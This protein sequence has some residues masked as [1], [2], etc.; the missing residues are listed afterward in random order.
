MTPVSSSEAAAVD[1]EVFARQ[2][3]LMNRN[4]RSGFVGSALGIPLLGVALFGWS[5]PMSF[6]IWAPASLGVILGAWLRIERLNSQGVATNEQRRTGMSYVL[7]DL[8]VGVVWG[9]AMVVFFDAQPARLAVL[10]MALLA[11]VV[12]A[13]GATAVF[14][15]SLYAFSAAGVVG[16]RRAGEPRWCAAARA[17][18]GGGSIWC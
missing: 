12:A 11:N 18:G 10:L 6:L 16:I 1:D 7:S 4:A 15:P 5:W 14:L 8:T 13:V 9:T 3:E 17:R 2:I